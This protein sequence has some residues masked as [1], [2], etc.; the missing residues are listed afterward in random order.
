MST[1]HD[2]SEDIRK[3]IQELAYLMWESAG[4]QQGMALDYWVAA[5]REV[6]K[7]MQAATERMLTPPSANATTS[8]PLAET[9][10]SGGAEKAA[11]AAGRAA[12]TAV[13]AAAPAEPDKEEA[14]AT[15]PKRR[16]TTSR[17]ASKA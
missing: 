6:M 3:R 16:A 14:T 5:E 8:S 4:R 9:S 15:K 10:A 1:L 2:I 17:A 11:I 12:V 13:E 7:T